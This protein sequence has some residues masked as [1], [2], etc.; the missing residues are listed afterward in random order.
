MT[1]PNPEANLLPPTYLGGPEITT[2]NCER[3]PIHI[4]GSVQPHGALLVVNAEG[5]QV[6]QAS[7]NLPAFLGVGAPEALG[8][9]L[10]ALLG[11]LAGVDGARVESQITEALPDGVAD[12]VQFRV[13]LRTGS[14]M[15][16]AAPLTLTAHRVG[17]RLIVELEPTQP[18]TVGLAYRRRN[19]VFA[20]EGAASLV[21]LAQVAVTAARDL[22][23]FDR[24]MLYRF[25]PD[26]S[27]EVLAEARREDLGS[28]L[29]HRFPASDIP[30]QARALY[31]R[32]LLRLTADVNAAPVPLL[33]RLDPVTNAPVPLGGAVLRATSPIH[34]Q[35]LRNM[36]VASSLSVSIVVD[37][38]LWG[39]IAC[40]HQTPHVTSPELRSTLEELGRLLNLQVQLKERAEVDAFRER[41][42]GG[43]QR[44]LQAAARS[45][46]PL[47]ALSDPGLRL[48]ELMNAGGLALHFEGQWRT[49]GAAPGTADLEALLGW[50]RATEPGT[51]YSTDELGAAWPPAAELPGV[52]SG[53]LALSIGHGWRE[54]LLWFRPEVPRTVAWGG[55][56]PEFAKDGLGPRQS[57]ETYLETVQGRALPWHEGERSEASALGETL[58]ATLGERLTTLR[59]LNDQLARSGAEWRELAFVIA[60]TVKEPVRLIHQ[61]V[62][63]FGLRQ[64]A[65]IDPESRTLSQFV[66]RETGR[67]HRLITDLYAYIELLSYPALSPVDVTPVQFVQ[68]VVDA[69]P[70][71]AGRVTVDVSGASGADRPVRVDAVKGREALRQVVVNALT[72]SPPGSAVTVTVRQDAHST[73]FTVADQ[74]PG[75]P[76]QY[77]DRAFQL[78]QRLVPGQTDDPAGTG[79]GLPLARKIA[80]LHGGTLSLDAAPGP[81]ARFTLRLPLDLP[82]PAMPLSGAGA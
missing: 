41:L 80:E 72:Y 70:G 63:L 16:S 11:G 30:P 49:L 21:E 10:G 29:A 4:P 28:F 78:F 53:L 5:G 81:G 46:A 67:L 62:E 82:A 25:A 39:L 32:H 52:A 58:T 75:I 48:R 14:G 31:V 42:R 69:V 33:P 27:G 22:S 74:G 66:T 55:A 7:E 1:G 79:L 50:L 60:H 64:G 2:E 12:N 76:P 47:D 18:D 36:G 37:G 35:Y 73:T 17:E 40:H 26:H 56:T 68:D 65:D 23:G 24:V 34:L 9:P 19:A 13:P 20:M 51:L 38:R 15:E 6:L 61:F 77:R 54:A 43:H 45:T 44:V 59:S 3:E 57:F 8:R 71:A